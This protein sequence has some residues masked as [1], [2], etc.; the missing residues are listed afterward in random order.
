MTITFL[1][2]FTLPLPAIPSSYVLKKALLQ[3]LVTITK[4]MIC[5]S[6]FL[7]VIKLTEDYV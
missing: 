1:L 4:Q 5:E 7:C 2:F 6:E 3:L